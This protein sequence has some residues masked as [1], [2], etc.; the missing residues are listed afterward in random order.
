MRFS[1]S[2]HP[3]IHELLAELDRDGPVIA[4]IWREAGHR[5]RAE[6]LLQPSY[7]T[8]WHI[9]RAQREQRS[10]EYSRAK[11]AAILAGEFLLNTRSRKGIL[12]DLY[13]GADLD[14]RREL[15]RRRA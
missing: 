5:A 7:A 15:Y 1:P 8:V 11:R 3:R 4:A 13:D 14:R 6:N 12:L 9:V 10:L 2:V